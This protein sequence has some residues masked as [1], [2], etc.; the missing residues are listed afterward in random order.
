MASKF[1]GE[2]SMR[3]DDQSWDDNHDACDNHPDRPAVLV[4]DGDGKFETIKL[5][6]ACV[7]PT[8]TKYLPNA[9]H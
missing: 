3:P 7:P 1:G 9:P 5:C 8:L 4:T 6:H 2:V